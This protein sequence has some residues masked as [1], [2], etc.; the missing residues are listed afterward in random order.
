VPVLAHQ[1]VLSGVVMQI[2]AQQP[3]VFTLSKH[4][5][6]GRRQVHFPPTAFVHMSRDERTSYGVELDRAELKT[7][8]SQSTGTYELPPDCY[9]ILH[10][11]PPDCYPIL[12]ELPPDC[13]TILHELPP[14]LCTSS[15]AICVHCMSKIHLTPPPTT[16]CLPAT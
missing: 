14:E 9:T 10:K 6:G 1:L 11:L 12:H 15:C 5:G 13:Y 8:G 16:N 2:M 7:V 4:E 3:A